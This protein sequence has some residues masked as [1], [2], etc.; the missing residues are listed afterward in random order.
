VYALRSYMIHYCIIILSAGI[1]GQ[2]FRNNNITKKLEGI[3]LLMGFTL[4]LRMSEV[5]IA[6]RSRDSAQPIRMP[7]LFELRTFLSFISFVNPIIKHKT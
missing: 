5:T 3:C 1:W 2:I 7:V 6:T 4:R